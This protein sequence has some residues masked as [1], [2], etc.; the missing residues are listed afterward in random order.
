MHELSIAMSIVD[1][2]MEEAQRRG[3]H[4]SSV[5]LRLGALSGVVKDALLFSYEVACQETP[6]QG[7]QL[8]VEDVPVVVFCAQCQAERILQSVQLFQC[9][10]CG[11]PTMDVR[12]GKELEVFALEV[13][14]EE[15]QG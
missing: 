6:L 12:K 4:V 9:P 1:A 14:E 11:T 13:Q 3:V 2:A 15:V 7:S 8:I 5:H 10:E